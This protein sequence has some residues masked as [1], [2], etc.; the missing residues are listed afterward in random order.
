MRVTL[1]RTEWTTIAPLACQAGSWCARCGLLVTLIAVICCSSGC[2]ALR[3]RQPDEQISAA[4]ELSIRGTDAQRRGQWDR[5]EQFYASAVQQ[6]PAD[7]RARCGLAESLWQ[8]GNREQAVAHMEQAVRLSGSDPLRRIQ[9]GQMYLSVGQLPR[10]LE[11]ADL[12]IEANG[13]LAAAWA[14][15]GD[16]FKQEARY[17]DALASYHRALAHQAHYPDVQLAVA[18]VY[19]KQDRQLRALSTVQQLA[20]QYPPGQTPPL[21]LYREALVLKDLKR[22]TDAA[23]SLLAA[24]RQDPQS[25]ELLFELSRVQMLAGDPASARLSVQAALARDPSHTASQA[26]FAELGTAA[27]RVSTASYRTQP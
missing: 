12:A 15:R 8:R 13:S 3:C 6:C 18:D 11:Q 4:R 21:V 19:Q 7:E 9:L 14:L 2:R 17:N 5:A 1:A 24:S 27:D 25:A 16:V 22:Y 26:M 20:D 23:N 10:A